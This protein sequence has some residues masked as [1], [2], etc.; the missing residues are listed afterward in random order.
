MAFQNIKDGLLQ[1]PQRRGV[2]RLAPPRFRS[3]PDGVAY[4]GVPNFYLEV[5][6]GVF[7]CAEVG[8]PVEE[9]CCDKRSE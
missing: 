6:A 8:G 1:M 5:A 3:P 2:S 9:V 4:S 7:A